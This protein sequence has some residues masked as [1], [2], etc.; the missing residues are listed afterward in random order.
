MRNRLLSGDAAGALSRPA[1]DHIVS[2]FKEAEG[3]DPINKLLYVDLKSYLVDNILTKVDRMSMAVSLEARVPLLEVAAGAGWADARGQEIEL[4]GDVTPSLPRLEIRETRRDPRGW[5]LHD[6]PRW[7]RAG[8]GYWSRRGLRARA[9]GN[10]Y[11][12]LPWGGL[13]RH[14]AQQL[15]REGNSA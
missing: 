15:L 5:T 6:L 11:D 1:N 9:R 4:V 2:L 14:Y 10:R 12:V 7:L 13:R 8:V 3:F